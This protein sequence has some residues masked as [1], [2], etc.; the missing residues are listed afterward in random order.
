MQGCQRNP[1]NLK[2]PSKKATAKGQFCRAQSKWT[3]AWDPHRFFNG[4]TSKDPL[5]STV[6]SETVPGDATT[7][8]RFFCCLYFIFLFFLSVSPSILPTSKCS[9]SPSFSGFALGQH[10]DVMKCVWCSMNQ[11]QPSNC[12]D[13]FITQM[14]ITLSEAP[15]RQL[16]VADQDKCPTKIRTLNAKL[17]KFLFIFFTF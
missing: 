15:A 16:P 17:T 6:K 2:V 8:T 7:K 4:S 14:L 13:F 11:S 5:D 9:L 3:T 10:M 1:P 12:F